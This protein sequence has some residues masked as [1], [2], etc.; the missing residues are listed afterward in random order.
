MVLWCL[1]SGTG[2][3]RVIV[4]CVVARPVRLVCDH[5]QAGKTTCLAHLVGEAALDHAFESDREHVDAL[6]AIFSATASR[7]LRSVVL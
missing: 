6:Y 4:A 1:V 7:L 5:V 3:A 2:W